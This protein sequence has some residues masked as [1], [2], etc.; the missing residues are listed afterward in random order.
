MQGCA[1]GL[2]SEPGLTVGAT[3]HLSG[4]AM[5]TLHHYDAIG[6]VVPGGRTASGC[7][8]YGRA[9]VARLWEVLFFREVGFSLEQIKEIVEGPNDRR[10]AALE[11][12][13]ALLERKAGRL[14]AMLDAVDGAIDAER[15]GTTMAIEGMLEMFGDF[16]PSRHEDEV[17]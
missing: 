4:V 8:L 12:H 11:R 7:R 14:R 5:R 3:A 1:V 9:G 13:R 6:L 16:D 2:V 17:R 15:R 10:T